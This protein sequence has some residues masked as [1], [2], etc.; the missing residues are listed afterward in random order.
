[1]RHTAVRALGITLFPTAALAIAL[2]VAPARWALAVHVWL[3][4]LLALAGI[5]GLRALRGTVPRRPSLFDSRPG[6]APG[7]NRLPELER[8]EREVTLAA[9]SAYDVHFRLRPTL[10]EAAL[11]LLAAGRGV[12]LDRQPERARQLLGEETWELVRA[13]REP[14]CD[15]RGPGLD[16]ARLERILASLESL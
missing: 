16:R 10:R 12:S 9:A 7:Q 2:L 6:A 13:D 1:M 14:P 3:L 5:A 8:L 4:V 11:T 15:P